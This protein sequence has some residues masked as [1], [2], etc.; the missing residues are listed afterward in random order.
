MK[1]DYSI[2]GFLQKTGNRDRGEGLF[3][4]ETERLLEVN[5]NGSVWTKM[6]S[7]VAYHGGVKFTREGILSQGMGNLLKKAVSGEGARQW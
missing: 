2:N 4:L 5:L 3:E 6:G 7:M 1:R